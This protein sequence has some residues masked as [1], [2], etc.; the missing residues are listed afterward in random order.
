MALTNGTRIGH[1]QVEALIGNG[2]LGE[3]YR[4]RDVRVHRQVA[5]K[6]LT[7]GVPASDEHLACFVRETRT[8][9]LLNHPNIATVYDVGT[10]ERAPFVVS[11]LLDG[12]TLRVKVTAGPLPAHAALRYARQIT[13]GLVAAH[14]IGVVH[15]DLKPENI[16]LTRGDVAK[17]LDF[18]LAKCRQDALEHLQDTSVATWPDT[19]LGTV[20][21]MSPEQIRGMSLD[22]RSDVFSVGAMLYEMLSGVPPFQ[23]DSPIETLGAILKD[24]VPAMRKYCPVPPDLERI[25]RHCL[26]KDRDYRFQSARDLLFNLELTAS[27]PPFLGGRG[28]RLQV[29]PILAGLRTTFLR[30]I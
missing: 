1:Y 3:V 28:N 30:L 18:G 4:A 22:E 17:I 21:Y 5:L 24:D 7:A 25:V 6:I 26:E 16:F 10:H 13:E 29:R 19:L 8:A 14:Q 20:G 15:R 12:E 9:A 23:R 27:G 2:G 11:E